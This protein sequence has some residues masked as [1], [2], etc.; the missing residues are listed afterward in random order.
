MR[1]LFADSADKL[2][3]AVERQMAQA[4]AAQEQLAW[5]R[6]QAEGQHRVERPQQRFPILGSILA[7]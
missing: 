1:D 5:D 6:I 4:E 7:L 3:E 2:T